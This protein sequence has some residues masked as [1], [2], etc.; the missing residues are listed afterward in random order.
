MSRRFESA[1]HIIYYRCGCVDGPCDGGDEYYDDY[2]DDEVE[3]KAVPAVPSP[4]VAAENYPPRNS[5]MSMWKEKET[6]ATMKPAA[7]ASSAKIDTGATGGGS[8]SI[9]QKW[10]QKEQDAIEKAKRPGRE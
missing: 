2:G 10:K 5:A 6:K 1:G 7:R 9:L 3:A 4:P 8:N